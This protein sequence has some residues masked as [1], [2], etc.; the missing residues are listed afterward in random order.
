[1]QSLLVLFD[2]KKGL[3]Q[4]LHYYTIYIYVYN[5]NYMNMYILV[6]CGA[7]SRLRS[8]CWVRCWATPTP[9]AGSGCSGP[10]PTQETSKESGTVPRTRPW[11]GP[12]TA[13]SGRAGSRLRYTF[14]KGRSMEQTVYS[15]LQILSYIL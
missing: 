6:R 3:L 15:T 9:P 5:V 2:D 11:L 13:S 4:S 12:T 7:R 1:M 10:S 14:Y 8:P